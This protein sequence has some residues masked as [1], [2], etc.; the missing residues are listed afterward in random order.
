[1]P[2]R[3]VGDTDSRVAKV[4]QSGGEKRA[5]IVV[6]EAGTRAWEGGE[7][8]EEDD[9]RMWSRRVIGAEAPP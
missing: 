5:D 1:V 3:L 6:A 2:E 9:N 8:G 7:L 4:R